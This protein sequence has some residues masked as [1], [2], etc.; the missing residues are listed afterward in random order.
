MNKYV[1]SVLNGLSMFIF[2]NKCGYQH[3][4]SEVSQKVL[5]NEYVINTLFPQFISFES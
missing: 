3:S 5:L 4:S 1:M 2:E